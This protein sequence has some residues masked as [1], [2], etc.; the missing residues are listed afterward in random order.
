MGITGL[1]FSIRFCKWSAV[2]PF[3]FVVSAFTHSTPSVPSTLSSVSTP[4]DEI[5]GLSLFVPLVTG[6]ILAIVGGLL[7]FIV[8]RYRA[9]AAEWLIPVDLE[10]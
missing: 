4:A 9:R 3:L 6:A 8:I 1:Y 10:R 5:Y 2:A 7:V